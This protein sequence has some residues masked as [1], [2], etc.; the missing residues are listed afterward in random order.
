MI[1]H[2]KLWRE[3]IRDDRAAEQANR[4]W[5]F[6]FPTSRNSRRELSAGLAPAHE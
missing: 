1:L 4:R 5:R 3:K 2:I 6:C